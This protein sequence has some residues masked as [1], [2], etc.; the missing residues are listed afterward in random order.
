MQVY[1]VFT[2][3][4]THTLLTP[5]GAGGAVVSAA[6]TTGA[7]NSQARL[8]A[9]LSGAKTELQL[10]L[11]TNLIPAP[12]LLLH[13]ANK[14]LPAWCHP[15]CLTGKINSRGLGHLSVLFYPLTQMFYTFFCSSIALA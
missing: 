11:Y 5:I 4:H 15:V 6:L 10:C 8:T 7:P 9:P 3:K 14:N 2:Y 13:N 1:P 12:A